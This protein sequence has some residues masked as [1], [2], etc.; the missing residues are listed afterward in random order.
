MSKSGFTSASRNESNQ[1]ARPK[2]KSF[3]RIASSCKVGMK[4][5]F[6]GVPDDVPATGTIHW[7]NARLLS[8]YRDG[9]RR[10]QRA[11]RV[12]PWGV[13]AWIEAMKIRKTRTESDHVDSVVCR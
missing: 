8:S 5:F 3:L 13:Q 2:E 12:Q 11:G 7:I 9:A 10:Y 4:E 6:E 1:V